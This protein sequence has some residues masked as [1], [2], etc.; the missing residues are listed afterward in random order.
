MRPLDAG[1]CFA[2]T[3]EHKTSDAKQ[4]QYEQV[5][6][7]RVSMPRSRRR[8]ATPSSALVAVAV[9]FTTATAQSQSCESYNS[10]STAGSLGRAFNTDP[11]Y[12]SC[13][14]DGFLVAVAASYVS[15]V[16]K[17][18]WTCSGGD[19]IGSFSSDSVA[20]GSASFTVGMT[21]VTTRVKDGKYPVLSDMFFGGYDVDSSRTDVDFLSKGPL[22]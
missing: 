19:D 9:I 16:E 1:K 18:S 11:S 2:A 10:S 3:V 22:G 20:E 8:A 12:F 15:S 5:F 7:W 4:T 17:L 13:A 6:L 14:D 21:E